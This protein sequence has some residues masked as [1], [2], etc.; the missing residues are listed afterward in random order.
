MH[1]TVDIE[2]NKHCE[3]SPHECLPPDVH[4]M[5]VHLFTNLCLL[6]LGDIAGGL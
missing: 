4:F 3:P 6:I 2:V 5:S 1:T